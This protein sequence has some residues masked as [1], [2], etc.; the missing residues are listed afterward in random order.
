MYNDR[1]TRDFGG[2]YWRV[3]RYNLRYQ[4]FL[5]LGDAVLIGLTLALSSLLRINID[6]GMEAP[7]EIFIPSFELY[8]IAP[9]IWVFAFGQAG[10]YS[11]HGST[12]LTQT[13][14]RVIAGHGLATLLFLGT[15]YITFRDFSRLQA[16][17]FIVLG[18]AFILVHRVALALLRRRL[19][20]YINSTRSVIVV[21]VSE[22]ARVVGERIRENH[23]AGLLLRGY[24]KPSSDAD[25]HAL[26]ADHVIGTVDDLPRLLSEQPTEEIIV[27]VK[28]F[29]ERASELVSHIM[30]LI[31]QF[32]VNI[33]IAP[34]Y[35]ELAYFRATPEDFY[36][37]TLVGLR[38][39]IMTPAQRIAKRAFDVVFSA[40]LLLISSP[41][42]IIL[43]ILIRLDSPGPAIFRQTRIGQH[44]RRF[45]IYKFRTMTNGAEEQGYQ[46][47]PDDPRVTRIGAFLRRTSLDE[48]P[49]FFNVL[50]GDMSVV[51]PRPEMTGLV[52]N[53]EWWQRKRF[54]VPQGITGW[55]QINGRSDKPMH[56]NTEDDLYYVRNYSF[57]L[58]MQIIAKTALALV[59]RRGAF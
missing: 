5:S 38:E 56:L 13:V 40:L 52:A 50:K 33:R 17:Y 31:D 35:S 26:P 15:L 32:P 58:D 42:F 41:L 30:H 14:R 28:W 49:Q 7:I 59:T 4:L 20:R 44:G 23:D 51:G 9:L 1:R 46:K 16:V 12:P 48:L 29:D 39:T 57:W 34:D 18:L 27:A 24:L 19:L 45:T 10:V 25:N 3:L 53:Y 55:W 8:L 6:I 36:G 11:A 43:P 54:E 47:K 21:G 2:S 22:N 37:I